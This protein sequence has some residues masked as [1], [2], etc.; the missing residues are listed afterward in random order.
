MGGLFRG[1]LVAVFVALMAP[2]SGFARDVRAVVALDAPS[3]A[4]S[5]A[6]SGALTSAVKAR[7]LDLRSATNRSYLAALEASQDRFERALRVVSPHARVDW[8]YRIVLNAVSVT[9]PAADL[10]R[11]E[12]LPG[13]HTVYRPSS[14]RVRLDRSPGFIGAPRLWNDPLATRGD[15]LK[16]AIV[17]DGIDQT[18]PFFSPAGYS[19][20]PGFPKGQSRYTTAK[21]IAARAFAPPGATWRNAAAAFD[22]QYSAHGTHVAG[23]AAGNANT[24]TSVGSAATGVAPRAYLGNYKVMTVPTERFGL[25]GNAPEIVRGIEAAVADGMDVINL[26]LG[27]PEVEPT[28]DVVA[29][30]LDGAAAAGVVPVV[31][32]G[33]DFRAAGRGSVVSPG[34]SRSA[35]TVGATEDANGVAPFSASG[36]SPLSLRLKPEVVAPGVTILSSVPAEGP[37]MW[38]LLSGTSMAAPHVAGGAALLRQRHPQW[39]VEQLKAALVATANPVG[40]D[41]V[42]RIGAGI[43][44][45]PDADAPL[46]FANPSTVSFGIVRPGAT[47]RA[48]IRLADAGGGAG[49]WEAAVVGPSGQRPIPAVTVPGTLTLTLAAGSSEREEA[50]WIVLRRGGVERRIPYWYTA[51]RPRL[52]AP[53]GT[54][55]RS[56]TYRGSTH[57][58]AARVVRYR[59]PDLAGERMRGPEQVFRFVLGRRAANFGVAVTSGSVEPRI[60]IARDENRVAGY[61]ALPVNAN[62]Y[63]DR[64]EDRVRTAAVINPTPRAYF[65]VFDSHGTRGSRFTFRVWVGD[66]TPPAARLLSSV[67]RGGVVRFH[68]RDGGSGV[69]PS[70]ARATVGG[71]RLGVRFRGAVASVD[72]SALRRGTHTLVFSV[73]DRQESKNNENVAG[74]LPNT[75]RVRAIIRVR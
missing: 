34:T 71:T 18:H 17:D 28:R 70:S 47:L 40:R 31:A 41:S 19:M 59:Y 3:L 26:S 13:V 48:S 24:P 64:F 42:L 74:V 75:R 8:R 23:V 7:R 20:P 33:N 14:Y 36:P 30:A 4:R 62:P 63:D 27:E 32:A 65:V 73:S 5:V 56:G 61:T 44:D 1:L 9:L 25:N 50:G 46:V 15:G 54:L 35:I 22:S 49:A 60:L 55:R 52:A 66:T 67:A 69:D 39:S 16:I 51:V 37:T 38:T 2:A 45:L 68:V 12:R 21:V 10:P 43:V 53:A 6:E 11:L 72:V 58:R 57:N 29:L